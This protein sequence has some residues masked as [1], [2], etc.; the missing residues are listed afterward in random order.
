M[1]Q[2]QKTQKPSC[3]ED[4]HIPSTDSKAWKRHGQRSR[5]Y[6]ELCTTFG[7]F[8]WEREREHQAALLRVRGKLKTQK[9]GLWANAEDRL[10]GKSPEPNSGHLHTHQTT[11]GDNTGDTH[12]GLWIWEKSL[13]SAD[14]FRQWL[15]LDP[16]WEEKEL[17]IKTH[18]ASLRVI[19]WRCKPAR[20]LHGGWAQAALPGLFLSS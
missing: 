18:C 13:F 14:L 3:Q 19:A 15:V 12:G 17:V 9:H 5:I 11:G 4:V 6:S 16:S 10:R 7:V 8:R 1:W 2:K 20:G